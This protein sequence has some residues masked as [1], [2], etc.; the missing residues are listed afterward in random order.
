MTPAPQV[1]ICRARR[2][3]EPGMIVLDPRPDE[4]GALVWT[5]G[6]VSSVATTLLADYGAE[7]TEAV[8]HGPESGYVPEGWRVIEHD[9]IA[10]VF[11]GDGGTGKPGKP[12]KAKPLAEVLD[13][14]PAQATPKVLEDPAQATLGAA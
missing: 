6:K 3:F 14:D 8:L 4:G 12:D 5:V 10:R 1:T 7:Q 11:S 9:K 2:R 13:E